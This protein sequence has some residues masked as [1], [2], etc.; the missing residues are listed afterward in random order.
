VSFCL[1]DSNM[2]H[3]ID[4]IAGHVGNRCY[5]IL[6]LS[7]KEMQKYYPDRPPVMATIYSAVAK[8]IGSSVAS[9]SKAVGRAVADIWE[10]GD[11]KALEQIAGRKL[12]EKPSPKDLLV[13]L[14]MQTINP[15]DRIQQLQNII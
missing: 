9:V 12:V 2:Y 8:Q 15:T 14:T 13:I 6:A 4:S 10:N 5:Y 11:R 1:G 7:V 3:V